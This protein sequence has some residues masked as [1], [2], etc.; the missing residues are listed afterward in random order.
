MESRAGEK[1]TRWPSLK[2]TSC[3]ITGL[4]LDYH[5]IH[6]DSIIYHPIALIIHLTNWIKLVLKPFLEIFEMAGSWAL[7]WQSNQKQISQLPKPFFKCRLKEPWTV[8][9][10]GSM[11]FLWYQFMINPLLQMFSDLKHV[12]TWSLYNRS[13][14]NSGIKCTL[15]FGDQQSQRWRSHP[16]VYGTYKFHVHDSFLLFWVPNDYQLVVHLYPSVGLHIHR[17]IWP[18]EVSGDS[19]KTVIKKKTKAKRASLASGPLPCLTKDTLDYYEHLSIYYYIYIYHQSLCEA[20]YICSCF[21]HFEEQDAI[22]DEH[23]T[24]ACLMTNNIPVLY[25]TY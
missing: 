8:V 5:W 12:K 3:D 1:I 11:S 17:S 24:R 18:S 7:D 20:P 13:I 21:K 19:S 14:V 23:R 6:T 25:S 4:S 15:L 2:P 22:A 10:I 16:L 9:N